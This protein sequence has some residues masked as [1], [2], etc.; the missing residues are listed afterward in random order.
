MPE[1]K[2]NKSTNQDLNR[3]IGEIEKDHGIGS[4]MF[5]GNKSVSKDDNAI[6]TGC[7][8]LDRA[9]GVGGY[10]RGR[11]VEIFG[12][13][14]SGK[15]TLTLHAIAAV[16]AA[17]GNAAF[18]DAEH[19]F[20][21]RYAKA[22]G[23]DIDRLLIAQPDYGEQALEIVDSLTRSGL[24][25]LIVVDSVAALVPRA[26]IEGDMGASHMGLQARLMS[27]ALRKLTATVNKTQ[28]TL[29]FINQLRQKIGVV[30][31]NPET[32]TGGNAMKFYSSL[33][34]DVRRIGKVTAGDDLVGNRTR[35]KL[36]KNKCAQPF[37][38]AEFDIRWG[39]GVDALTD[40][41]D[42]A[43]SDGVLDKNGAYYSFAGKSIGQGREKTREALKQNAEL[44]K[45]IHNAI[46]AAEAKTEQSSAMAA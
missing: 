44:R 40:L 32:T 34:L 41:I 2:K 27:Q 17:G 22:I 42:I 31:G 37:T 4:I 13:E 16:Q 35:V 43:V 15:T 9:V 30:F 28:T 23:V 11:I 3:I 6:P 39:I 8:A 7:I 45:K 14:S 38:E 1:K 36:V 46:R 25:D 12:P 29:M 21:L 10:P 5:L 19:A 20:D 18:I 24:L 26:E 33:R